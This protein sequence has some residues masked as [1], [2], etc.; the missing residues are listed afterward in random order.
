ML[1]EIPN[2]RGL[3]LLIDYHLIQPHNL[4]MRCLKID[5]TIGWGACKRSVKFMPPSQEKLFVFIVKG[6]ILH[7]KKNGAEF[8]GLFRLIFQI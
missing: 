2:L 1:D 5:G 8:V 4:P 7:M 6:H 3:I